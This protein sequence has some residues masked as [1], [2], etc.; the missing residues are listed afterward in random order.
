MATWRVLSHPT[1][2]HST[3]GVDLR[4]PTQAAARAQAEIEKRRPGIS[5]VTVHLCSHVAGEPASEWY[6]CQD[7]ARSEYEEF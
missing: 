3:S 7:D 6:N 4:L 1:P 2:D 5:R